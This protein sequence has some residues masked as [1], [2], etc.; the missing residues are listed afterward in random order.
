MKKLAPLPETKQKIARLINM[1][2]ID[3]LIR[4]QKPFEEPPENVKLQLQMVNGKPKV[5]VEDW[6]EFG[7]CVIVES[8][9]DATGCV[10]THGIRKSDEQSDDQFTSAAKYLLNVGTDDQ[11]IDVLKRRKIDKM[12]NLVC[13]PV[14]KFNEPKVKKE[15]E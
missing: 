4:L 1:D 13:R 2:G 10:F 9:S 11:W 6:Q 3:V 15:K 5:Y 12:L 8:W 14:P 7:T